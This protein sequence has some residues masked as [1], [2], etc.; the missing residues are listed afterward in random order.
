[1]ADLDDFYPDDYDDDF[2][3]PKCDG[4]GHIDCHC[5]GDLCVCTNYGERYCPVCG[6]DGNVTEARYEQ[7]RAD[8]R[9]WWAA[10]QA[11]VNARQ[12]RFTKEAPW[13]LRAPKPA[14]TTK[15]A[16]VKAAR[17]QRQRNG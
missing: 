2:P 5:G 15:R 12:R 1:M 14:T 10:Y 3:C 17:K 6:G 9:E 11:A 7:Y 16:K 8:E 13:K 4:S